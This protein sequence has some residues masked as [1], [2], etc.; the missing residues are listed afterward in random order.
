[1]ETSTLARVNE[2]PPEVQE[3]VRDLGRRFQKRRKKVERVCELCGKVF[4]AYETA[5][6]CSAAH[7]LKAW[8]EEQRRAAKQKPPEP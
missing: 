2:L 4:L 6:Y 5:R 8:R 1:M 3:L 7:R